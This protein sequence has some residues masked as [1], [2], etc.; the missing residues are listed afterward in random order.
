VP[1]EDN[2]DVDICLEDKIVPAHRVVLQERS[3]F[4]HAGIGFES[5]WIHGAQGRISVE[6][7][8]IQWKYY[9]TVHRYFYLKDPSASN[10]FVGVAEESVDEFTGY[11]MN[12]LAVAD[13]LLIYNLKDICQ[14]VLCKLGKHF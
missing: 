11:V 10:V 5:L 3:A 7:P 12:V 13:E 14:F 1:N 4:Y 8:N 9:K 2:D 6:L